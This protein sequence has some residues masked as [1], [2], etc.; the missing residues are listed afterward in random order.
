[1][2]RRIEVDDAGTHDL[3]VVPDLAVGQAGRAI[4]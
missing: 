2:T 1:M 3:R 4:G